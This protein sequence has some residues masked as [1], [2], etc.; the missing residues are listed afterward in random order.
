[1]GLYGFAEGWAQWQ[2][3]AARAIDI[4]LWYDCHRQSLKSLI[5]CAE[6]HAPKDSTQRFSNDRRGG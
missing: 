6:H 3:V 2:G 1:V 4:A 5:R